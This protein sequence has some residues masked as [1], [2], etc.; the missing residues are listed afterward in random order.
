[1]NLHFNSLS[2]AWS[3]LSFRTNA[4]LLCMLALHCLSGF[5]QVPDGTVE[6]YLS[7]SRTLQRAGK[8]DSAM[9]VLAKAEKDLENTLSIQQQAEL[10]SKMGVIHQMRGD[11]NN[12]LNLQ[13]SA[14]ELSEKAAAPKLTSEVLN[15]I[16]AIHH[17]QKNYDDALRYYSACLDLREQLGNKKDLALSYNNFGSLFEDMG[18]IR[19]AN[20][21]L[22]KS[23][24]FWEQL[25]DSSWIAVTY[26]NLGS[27]LESGG[28][29][30]SALMLYNQSLSM[31]NALGTGAKNGKVMSYIGRVMLKKK[32]PL[33]AQMWCK[34]SLQIGEEWGSSSLSME[35][36]QCLQNAADLLN[37]PIEAYDYFRRYVAFKDSLSSQNLT[38]EL[39]KLEM[40]YSFKKQLFADSLEVAK[41]RIKA[42]FEFNERITKQRN[43][44]NTF[45]LI[46]IGILILAAGLYNRLRFIRNAKETIQAERDRSDHLLLNILPASVAEELKQNGKAA[47]QDYDEVSVLF[48]DFIGFTAHSERLSAHELLSELNLY[49]GKFDQIAKLR[50]LEKI[51]TIGDAYMLAGGLPNPDKNAV[52][53]IIH[54]ALDM[55][56]FMSEIEKVHKEMGKPFFE[57]R[58]GIHTG[59]I[60]AGIV[61]STKFQYDIWGDTVN[62]ASRLESSSKPGKLN[63]SET[64]YNLAKRDPSLRFEARGKIQV[65]GKG[66]LEMYFVERVE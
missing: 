26:A 5:A 56:E 20:I 65:K 12:A 41:D 35:S 32:N 54:A 27:C 6:Q 22:S 16:G 1:M 24:A 39:T 10:K 57:M 66:A 62:T 3:G 43:Q 13:F 17:I 2:C 28:K 38:R 52:I 37:R 18:R 60:V 7:V 51:K 61:G 48:T 29:L 15:N 59:P 58:L 50:G 64:T 4:L 33:A 42:E 25:G 44:R 53:N 11:Y 30:D 8:L 21:N 34:Q 47:A 45:L 49:F 63:I 46:G 40:D 14:L 23:L 55:Q 31:F 19:E 9:I 36:C